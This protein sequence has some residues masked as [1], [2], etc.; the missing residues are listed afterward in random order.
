MPQPHAPR[1]RPR[2]DAREAL[3]LLAERFGARGDA[4]ARRATL[5]FLVERHPNARF[6]PRARDALRVEPGP[7]CSAAAPVTAP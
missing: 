2:G 1:P 7:A 5:C 4:D 6:A 3:W